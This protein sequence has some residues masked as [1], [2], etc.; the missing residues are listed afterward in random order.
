MTERSKNLL[1]LFVSVCLAICLGEI[2]VRFL[3]TDLFKN[4]RYYQCGNLLFC[5]PATA[6]FD[7]ALGFRMRPHLDYQFENLAFSV[8]VKTNS[9]GFRDDEDSLDKPEFLFLGDSFTFGWGVEENECVVSLFEDATGAKALNM[10][11]P[12]Y[13][14][15]QETLLLGQEIESLHAQRQKVILLVYNNDFYDNVGPVF[16]PFPKVRKKGA[17]LVITD[18][19]EACYRRAQKVHAP[20]L[21]KTLSQYSMAAYLVCSLVGGATSDL[22]SNDEAPIEITYDRFG[23]E[24]NELEAFEYAMRYLKSVLEDWNLPLYTVYIPGYGELDHS[25]NQFSKTFEIVMRQLEIPHLD[26]T[27]H[28]SMEDYY[29]ID[30]HFNSRGHR[31]AAE[32]IVRFLTEAGALEKDRAHPALTGVAPQ[33]GD[34]ARIVTAAE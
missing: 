30:G 17:R 5:D 28:L 10:G 22:V 14:N 31:T 32:E 16:S 4:R 24:L 19:F 1:L 33:D 20:S 18:P 29:R 2:L 27:D 12:G 7:P 8:N 21:A 3:S 11:E 34:A 23:F 26:L 6:V 25:K 15:I 9:K 13:G